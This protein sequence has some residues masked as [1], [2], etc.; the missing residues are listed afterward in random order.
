[1]VADINN[2]KRRE[3]Q[4][5]IQEAKRITDMDL[6]INPDVMEE[7]QILTERVMS[8]EMNAQRPQMEASRHAPMIPP[9][10]KATAITPAVLIGTS[11]PRAIQLKGPDNPTLIAPLKKNGNAPSNAHKGPRVETKAG[12]KPES[13]QP[14]Q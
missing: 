1:M 3:V 12:N 4:R 5:E 8:E 7:V 11:T 9:G 10:E 14:K 13:K 2:R 6:E